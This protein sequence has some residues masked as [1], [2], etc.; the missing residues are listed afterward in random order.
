MHSA[1]FTRI[2]LNNGRRVDDVKFVGVGRNLDV[3]TG[4]DRG[5]GEESTRG[6]PAL[7]AAAG[8][9]VLHV[10]GERDFHGV[11][12]AVTPERATWEVGIALGHVVLKT[13]M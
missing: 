6:F 12:D 4:N 2:T 7:G 5:D 8:V 9:V 11:S 3:L 10:T 1:L 13:W